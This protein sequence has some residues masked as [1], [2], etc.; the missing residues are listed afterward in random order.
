MY[1][2]KTYAV[3]GLGRYGFSVAVELESRGAE[4]IAIDSD[5]SAVEEAAPHLTV[6]KCADVTDRKVL[7]QL[8][9]ANVGTVIVAMASHL[10]A[11]VMAVMLCKE[12]G[13]AN[14]IAKCAD[15]THSRI[16]SKVGADRV[17]VPEKESGIRLARNLLSAG[18]IDMV[19]LSGRVSLVELEMRKD[20]VG[21]NLIELNL[22]EKYGINV[23]ALRSGHSV[24]TT[25]DP[26]MPL[27]EEH[28]LIVIADTDRLGK[29]K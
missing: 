15:D 28:C 26:K 8:G 9:I 29:L 23:V 7:E 5:P 21:K 16:L 20:W 19:E 14:V 17:V 25:V 6:C 24:F 13:V 27:R 1:T 4:V 22:R 11:S 12:L 10:E 3:F 2:N 18:F